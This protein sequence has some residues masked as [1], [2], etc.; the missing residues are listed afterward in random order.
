MPLLSSK[1]TNDADRV[2]ISGLCIYGMVTS[3]TTSVR[4]GAALAQDCSN[5]TRSMPQR[6][7]TFTRPLSF[8]AVRRSA[9]GQVASMPLSVGPQVSASRT[10]PNYVSLFEKCRSSF[11]SFSRHSPVMSGFVGGSRRPSRKLCMPHQELSARSKIREFDTIQCQMTK[12]PLHAWLVLRCRFS[13]FPSGFSR[14][15]SAISWQTTAWSRQSIDRK[16]L[17]DRDQRLAGA[18]RGQKS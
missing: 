11:V 18:P 17:T 8:R 15:I 6:C 3:F 1:Q 13:D 10:T 12:S 16:P 9:C 7:I 4:P 2:S 5:T 14:R